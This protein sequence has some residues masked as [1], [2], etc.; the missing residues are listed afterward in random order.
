MAPAAQTPRFSRRAKLIIGG[1]V[2]VVTVLY[3]FA[4]ALLID[5]FTRRGSTAIVG[6]VS[7]SP[8]SSAAEP[9]PSNQPQAAVSANSIVPGAPFTVFGSNWAPNEAVTI[10][11]R[12]PAAPSEPLLFLGH[13]PGRCERSRRGHCHLSRRFPLGEFRSGRR[14]HPIADQRRVCLNP[15]RATAPDGDAV[16]IA[17][18]GSDARAAHH[19]ATYGRHADAGAAYSHPAHCHADAPGLSR[20]ARRIL[21]QHH[22]AWRADRRAQ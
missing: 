20:L 1:A 9:T 8:T 19:A 13:Q 16:S 7:P 2:V 10:F 4:C 5:T 12:D 18:A 17:D 3:I 15:H 21:C 22:A 6:P 14:D 11:L